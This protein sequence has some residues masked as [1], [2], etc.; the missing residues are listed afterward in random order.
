MRKKSFAHIKCSRNE[1]RGL[2]FSAAL[3]FLFIS[4]IVSCTTMA[5]YDFSTVE[6]NTSQGRFTVA[7]DLLKQDANRIYT[8]HDQVLYGLDQGMLLHFA[9]KSDESTTFLSQ[10]EQ[11][12]FDYYSKSI[13]QGIGAYITNDTV[14]DYSGETYEDIYT[15]I[16]MAL[17]YI[18]KNDTENAMVE[19]RR[20][21]NKLKEVSAQYQNQ[22]YQMKSQVDQKQIVDNSQII[23][24]SNIEFHNSA[25]ARYLSMILY[26]AEGDISSAQVD[27]N[28]LN[29][30][31]VTEPDLYTF[32]LPTTLKEELVVDETKARLN[33]ISFTGK[34][35]VKYEESTRIVFPDGLYYKIAYPGMQKRGSSVNSIR[36][37]AKNELTGEVYNANA[38]K[39]ESIEN[40]AFDTFKQKQALVY[41]RALVR[42][43]FKT[44]TTAIFGSM[45]EKSTTNEDKT[46]YR[47]LRS[48]SSI[49]NEITERADVRTSRYFP[50]LA[51]VTGI[52]LPPGTYTITVSY[53][54]VAGRTFAVQSAEHFEIKRNQINLIESVCLK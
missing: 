51:S 41:G 45:E 32:T 15:N 8:Q 10:A 44:S 6:Q 21:D 27:M 47:M 16:F 9:G 42:S 29:S 46:L 7:A 40:I 31:F 38:E 23:S 34:A 5:D 33:L 2:I 36:L 54:D 48:F 11:K 37:V 18:D 53:A 20:F 1:L 14:M 49:A 28:L 52:S 50:A 24:T 26:R 3:L 35:P 22:I 19:I 17:N 25:L 4:V 39:I 43:L 12:I 13:T 30:A